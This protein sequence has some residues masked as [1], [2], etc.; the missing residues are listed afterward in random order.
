MDL[1]LHRDILLVQQQTETGF[2]SNFCDELRFLGLST[3]DCAILD[4]R[5]C[6][7][8]LTLKMFR[9][10]EVKGRPIVAE[11]DQLL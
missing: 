4:F 5:S 2:L 10:P 8:S 6:S 1:F 9:I 3:P 11:L 7:K